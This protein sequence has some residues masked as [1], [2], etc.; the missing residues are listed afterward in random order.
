MRHGRDKRAGSQR[1][2]A[3]LAGG[4]I[5][6]VVVSAVTFA[7]FA[8]AVNAEFVG[9]DDDVL[10]TKNAEF[11]G[12]LPAS[13]RWMFS[14]TLLGNYMPLTWLSYRA[15]FAIG[16]LQPPRVHPAH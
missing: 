6:A 8:P 15:N 11:R 1:A 7:A 4:I 14:T 5:G 13:L 3:G 10:L 2:R 16:G 12:P 9:W